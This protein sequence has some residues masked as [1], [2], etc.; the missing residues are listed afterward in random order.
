MPALDWQPRFDFG[1]STF[2]A[3][4][5]MRI[6]EKTLRVTGGADRAA[7]WLGASYEISRANLLKVTIRYFESEENALFVAIDYMRT[8]PQT[9][10]WYPD[11]FVTATSYE[12]DVESPRKGEDLVGRQDPDFPQVR[13]IDVTFRSVAGTP[14]PMNWFT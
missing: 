11:K 3:T 1:A 7:S 12:I 8:W 10:T 14:W 4:L 13:E 5:P 9:G 6:W 2:S